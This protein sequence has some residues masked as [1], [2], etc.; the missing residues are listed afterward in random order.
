M[1]HNTRLVYHHSLRRRYNKKV[2]ITI[3][4]LYMMC[5]LYTVIGVVHEGITLLGDVL[6]RLPDLVKKV[7]SL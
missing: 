5:T 4:L 1:H 6:L 3:M 2:L 7:S